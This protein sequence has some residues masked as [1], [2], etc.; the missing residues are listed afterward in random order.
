VS[1]RRPKPKFVRISLAVLKRNILFKFTAFS[2]LGNYWD[3]KFDFNNSG[4]WDTIY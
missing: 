1:T 2:M 3:I 4:V